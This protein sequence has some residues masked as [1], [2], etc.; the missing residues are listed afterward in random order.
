MTVISSPGQETGRRKLLPQLGR[1]RRYQIDCQRKSQ[2]FQRRETS[3]EMRRPFT[4]E[5]TD[6]PGY[7]NARMLGTPHLKLK[8][9][10]EVFET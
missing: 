8:D 9:V 2:A 1:S 7:K 6:L 3:K 5:N 4:R 10:T